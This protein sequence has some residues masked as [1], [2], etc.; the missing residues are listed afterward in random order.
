MPLAA[1]EPGP[2]S[3]NELTMTQELIANMLGVA[4]RVVT[5]AAGKLQR[6]GDRLQPRQ[7]HRAGPSEAGGAG[8]RVLRGGEARIRPPAAEGRAA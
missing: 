4:A 3:S 2:L 1:P 6:R 7:D 8:V 5:E